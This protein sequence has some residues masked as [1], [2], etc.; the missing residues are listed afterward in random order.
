MH[1]VVLHK[2]RNVRA[3]MNTRMCTRVYG[4]IVYVRSYGSHRKSVLT[5]SVKTLFV[6]I[7]HFRNA[8]INEIYCV[9]QNASIC[10]Q[11]REGHAP[12]TS[13]WNQHPCVFLLWNFKERGFSFN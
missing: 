13:L 1:F 9:D 11:H 5:V 8:L 12:L 2:Q 4:C 7:M 10:F 6:V 3:C